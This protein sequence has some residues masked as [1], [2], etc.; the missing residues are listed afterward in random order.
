[1]NTCMGNGGA[2]WYP[3]TAGS[4]P[5]KNPMMLAYMANNLEGDYGIWNDYGGWFYVFKW[6]YATMVANPAYVEGGTGADQSP[7][8]RSTCRRPSGPGSAPRRCATAG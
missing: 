4:D 8:C 5:V 1:M 2:A 3:S 7:C 6:A